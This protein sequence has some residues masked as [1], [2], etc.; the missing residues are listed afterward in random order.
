MHN[1]Q[2]SPAITAISKSHKPDIEHTYSGNA[3]PKLDL[4]LLSA[5]T[6]S[7]DQISLNTGAAMDAILN[8]FHRFDTPISSARVKSFLRRAFELAGA[9][10][11]DG[12]SAPL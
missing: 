9:P 4:Y 6:N 11:A 5:Y 12:H 8:S 1:R 7:I 2:R 3:K 10:Y